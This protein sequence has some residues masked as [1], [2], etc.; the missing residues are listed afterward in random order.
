[1]F[2]IMINSKAIDYCMHD[3]TTPL[4]SLSKALYAL[5]LPIVTV[6][7][8]LFLIAPNLAVMVAL[9]SYFGLDLALSL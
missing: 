7:S 5:I 4:F 1:M 3:Q 9:F 8:N 6:I 2:V